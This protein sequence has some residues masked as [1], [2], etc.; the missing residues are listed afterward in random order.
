MTIT[1]SKL[2]KLFIEYNEK[3][4]DSYLSFPKLTTFVGESSMGLFFVRKKKSGF[5]EKEIAIARNF[6]INEEELR[7]LI[8]HEMI[9]QYVYEKYGKMNHGRYFKRK[10]NELNKTYGLDIRKNSKHLFKKYGYRK[11]FFGKIVSM[12]RNKNNATQ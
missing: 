5:I 10:M 6:K 12:F 8:L 9:H 7:D 3:Y 11:T 4:F 2:R 1:A